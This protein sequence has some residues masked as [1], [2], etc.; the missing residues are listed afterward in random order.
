MTMTTLLKRTIHAGFSRMG[1]EVHRTIHC[2]PL[3]P[4][5]PH[6]MLYPHATY[7]PWLADSE[8]K[9]IHEAVHDHTLVDHYR[10]YELWTLAARLGH[11]KGDVL[12][13]GV[14][15]GGSGALIAKQVQN[16][17]PNRVVYLC[18]TF[19][20]VVGVGA[21]DTFYKGGE[22]ADTSSYTVQ[23]LMSHL[24]LTNTRIVVGVF[25]QETAS[26][27]TSEA[28]ALVHID[29]DVHDS[30][31]WCFEWVWPRMVAGGTVVFDDYGFR[32]CE[33]VTQMVNEIREPDAA[34]IYN[35]N[36]HAI[37]IQT[38]QKNSSSR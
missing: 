15:R 23:E 38:A 7:S 4:A 3:V 25:P 2:Q 36:G 21:R 29:V 31:K 10:C 34:I 27:V 35:L 9:A 20:G 17:T 28:F 11:L 26:K 33:G 16:V 13:I 30:A 32:G 24:G 8:F 1:L 37:A 6:S 18:D 22:H 19:R 12:E 5:I 14:W